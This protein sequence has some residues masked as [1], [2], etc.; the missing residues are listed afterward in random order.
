[1]ALVEII[2]YI[3]AFMRKL[4]GIEDE[5][6]KQDYSNLSGTSDAVD[7]I[8]DGMTEANEQAEKLKKNLLGI[9]E[10][11]ILEPETA[12]TDDL[13]DPT[14]MTA[15]EAALKDWEN[16]MDSVNMKAYQVRDALLSWIGL[17]YDE[18]GNPI[19]K[20]GGKL[21]EFLG[22]VKDAKTWLDSLIQSGGGED[23]ELPLFTLL[24]QLKQKFL[25][26]WQYVDALSIT[27]LEMKFPLLT[28]ILKMFEGIGEIID[29]GPD[30]ENIMD[31]IEGIGW[32]L[33]AIG[34]TLGLPVFTGLG[35]FIIGISKTIDAINKALEDGKIELNEL[36]DI[37]V[38]IGVTIAGLALMGKIKTIIGWLVALKTWVWN[39]A[40][41]IKAALGGSSAA[42]S[43]LVFLLNKLKMIFSWISIIIGAFEIFKNIA[44]W[45]DG[46]ISPLQALF[47]I[48]KGIALIVMGIMALIGNWIG[49]GIATAAF[50]A[51]GIAESTVKN[52]SK[53]SEQETTIEKKTEL[54]VEVE[55]ELVSADKAIS[56]TIEKLKLMLM[57]V[58]QIKDCLL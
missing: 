29:R 46:T 38:G 53:K 22:K 47:G 41:A 21:D 35:L 19:A 57:V 42:A 54:E 31:I 37:L 34:T 45:I 58:T 49:F 32:I 43:A 44:G 13:I 10:L 24:D 50:I 9:D 48:L 17:E 15:F 11:N 2:N 40:I 5:I 26:I 7:E 56:S 27:L 52:S 3:S 14:I 33:A 55:T 51:A 36:D 1:M 23:E 12:T 6:K 39:V 4:L 20:M 8:I 25:E 30:F 18:E 16:R 28:G